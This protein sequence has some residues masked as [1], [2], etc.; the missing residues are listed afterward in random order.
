[1][2]I[3]GLI[4][5]GLVLDLGGGPNHDRLGFRYWKNPGAFNEY[6]MTGSAGGFLAFWKAMVP[7]AFSYGNIQIVAISGSETRDP[8]KLIPS[9]TKKVFWRILLFYICS[10]FIVG[11]IVPYDDPSLQLSSGTASQSPFTVAFERSGVPVVSS[12]INAVVLTSAV[13]A[14]SACIFIASRTLFGL[15]CDGHAP[16]IMQR[17]NRMGVPY[18]AVATT[19]VPLPL[20]YLVLGN[21]ASIVFGWF[22]NITTVA[23]LIGWIVIEIT[24]LRF[25]QGLK[26]QG[27][28]RN[29]KPLPHLDHIISM[30]TPIRT[31][32]QIP[33]PALHI[34]VHT[35][36]RLLDCTLLRLR[37]LR[38]RQLHS[39]RL[40]YEL[41]QHCHLCGPVPGVQDHA[42]VEDSQ[43]VRVGLRYRVC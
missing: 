13:S 15:S 43:N 20:V 9:A 23:G 21:S 27:Y 39:R 41:S 30:L 42:Q 29:G 3:I 14:A 4:I 6:I 7:A 16:K 5:G 2:L 11:L 1:M 17:C 36:P 32:L 10:I 26:R 37:H 38:H 35:R 12:I 18:Y 40:P 22:L 33:S 24:Y 19:C 34:L 8:R 28:S 25:Y 31:T